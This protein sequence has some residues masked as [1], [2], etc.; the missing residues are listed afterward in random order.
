MEGWAS[1]TALPT[2]DAESNVHPGKDGG[3][4]FWTIWKK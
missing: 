3:R 4:P 1:R 2:E